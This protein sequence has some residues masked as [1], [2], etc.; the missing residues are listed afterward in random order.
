MRRRVLRRHIWGDSVGLCPIKRTPGLYGLTG[1]FTVSDEPEFTR[2]SLL[3][4]S[5]T[6]SPLSELT[7]I[8]VLSI[9]LWDLWVYKPVSPLSAQRSCVFNSV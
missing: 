4:G 1:R 9:T 7:L 3:N 6:V 2:D 8:N 5:K